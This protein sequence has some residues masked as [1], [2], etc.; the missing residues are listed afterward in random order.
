M[1][2]RK[3]AF[4]VVLFVE[5]SGCHN[6]MKLVY[7]VLVSHFFARRHVTSRYEKTRIIARI[8]G[9]TQE[10]LQD[11]EL[12][13]KRPAGVIGCRCL[14]AVHSLHTCNVDIGS[15]HFL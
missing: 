8:F 2:S 13:L 4:Y 12:S 6:K 5:T 10:L 15:R 7:W 11:V 1:K 14:C 9:S 3:L